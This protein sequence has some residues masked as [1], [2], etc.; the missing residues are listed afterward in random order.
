MGCA[1]G[2]GSSEA[3]STDRRS[4]DPPGTWK[5]GAEDPRLRDPKPITRFW[6]IANAGGKDERG[7]GTGQGSEGAPQNSPRRHPGSPRTTR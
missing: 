5:S 3:V 2:D 7:T 1:A 6:P 4:R